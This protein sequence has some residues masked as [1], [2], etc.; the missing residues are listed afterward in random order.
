MSKEVQQFLEMVKQA[1]VKKVENRP[2]HCQGCCRETEHY[3]LGRTG[4]REKY[5]CCICGL[6]REVAV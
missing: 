6:I 4:S 1:S 5:Q 2:Y 3:Y